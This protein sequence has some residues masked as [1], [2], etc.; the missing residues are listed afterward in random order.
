MPRMIQILAISGSL[1]AASSNTALVYAAALLA[2]SNV[3][4][5]I[6]DALG[7][8]PHFNPDLD[9]DTPP[10]A[11]AAW[12]AQ[13]RAAD[14]V[15]ICSPEYAHGVPGSLKNG[16]DWLVSSGELMDKPLALVN[17][18]P[19]STFAQAQLTEILTVM[20]ARVVPEAS[21]TLPVSGKNLDAAGIAHHPEFAERLRD[22]LAALIADCASHSA[23]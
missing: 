18:S 13:W 20:M 6:S 23:A 16:L 8:L 4:I 14:A 11:V 2:P 7:G 3:E 1:R 12:R 5:L 22:A 10:A 9:T 17:I 15:L 21:P 19:R